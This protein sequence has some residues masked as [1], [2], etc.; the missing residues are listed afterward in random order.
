MRRRRLT[1]SWTT[2]SPNRR[3]LPASAYPRAGRS[4][5]ALALHTWVIAQTCSYPKQTVGRRGGGV[6]RL[7][8]FFE[9]NSSADGERP[10]VV[11]RCSNAAAQGAIQ[12][13]K[14]AFLAAEPPMRTAKR[15]L[16][17]SRCQQAAYFV[18]C[19]GSS[20]TKDNSSKS[21]IFSV[22]KRKCTIAISGCAGASSSTPASL[23]RRNA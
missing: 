23:D 10:S 4:R 2:W 8:L 11:I 14:E 16:H 19:F 3:C 12:R 1:S 9:S 22:P 15:L 7:L 20:G 6:G 18:T 5:R 13:G 21:G 17:A